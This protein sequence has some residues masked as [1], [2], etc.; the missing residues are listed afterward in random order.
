M[1]SKIKKK[2]GKN[3]SLKRLI[4]N[5]ERISRKDLSEH[6]DDY[7]ERCDKED[8]AFV[9][10][11]EGKDDLILCPAHWFGIVADTDFENIVGC[12]LRYSIGRNTYMPTVVANYVKRHIDLFGRVS[13][14]VMIR[15]IDR[16]L[17]CDIPQADVWVSL[18]SDLEAHR[19]TMLN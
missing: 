4:E 10:S 6:L 18:K 16:E 1:Q 11:D 5:M 13:V 3:M 7:L 9:I 8:I 12:A 15:D 2:E 14:E 17:Q 19:E